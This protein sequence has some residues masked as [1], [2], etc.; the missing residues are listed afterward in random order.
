MSVK[1]ATAAIFYFVNERKNTCPCC[2]QELFTDEARSKALNFI[3]DYCSN[4]RVD[5]PMQPQTA[6]SGKEGG[7]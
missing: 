4:K 5:A 1:A 2:G 3:I 6:L 7:R